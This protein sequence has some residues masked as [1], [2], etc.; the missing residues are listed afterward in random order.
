MDKGEGERKKEYEQKTLA[1]TIEISRINPYHDPASLYDSRIT[2]LAATP[3]GFVMAG[4]N[5]GSITIMSGNETT[6]LCPKDEAQKDIQL[7]SDSNDHNNDVTVHTVHCVPFCVS[8]RRDGFVRVHRRAKDS[9][10]W[11]SRTLKGAKAIH[12]TQL[13]FIRYLNAYH[14]AAD[15][16]D[17]IGLWDSGGTRHHLLKRVH[18]NI[19]AIPGTDE[20]DSQIAVYNKQSGTVE[21]YNLSGESERKKAHAASYVHTENVQ[22]IATLTG[23]GHA[24]TY[25]GGVQQ[26]VASPDG[27]YLVSVC[28][29]NIAK[30]WNVNNNQVPHQVYHDVHDAAF[31]HDSET[32]A[33]A[34]PKVINLINP[35]TGATTRSI[36]DDD[37]QYVRSMNFTGDKLFVSST[38]HVLNY[39]YNERGLEKQFP[40]MT[41]YALLEDGAIVY[42]TVPVPAKPLEWGNNPNGRGARVVT[43]KSTSKP[44]YLVAYGSPEVLATCG[45]TRQLWSDNLPTQASEATAPASTAPKGARE[46]A[47]G[48]TPLAIP[49]S[50]RVETPQTPQVAPTFVRAYKRELIIGSL[51]LGSALIVMQLYAKSW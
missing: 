22:S 49:M 14:V 19:V 33:L 51:V 40:A 4:G 18:G 45:I 32:L 31:S 11:T 36:S 17:G 30:L 21:T 25:P 35:K 41:A 50:S 24:I 43:K 16:N 5:G 42:A 9:G 46:N 6:R 48:D 12:S 37:A 7:D 47:P 8:A 10:E 13:A 23:F 44:S 26:V 38:G 27:R 29:K 2:S 34:Q 15:G 28:S 20:T 3:R 39:L 1:E